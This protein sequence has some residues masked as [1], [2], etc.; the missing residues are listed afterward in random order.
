[1][2]PVSRRALG[3]AI[4]GYDRIVVEWGP[5]TFERVLRVTSA[6][7]G[8][9]GLSVAAELVGAAYTEVES[10]AA[11][12]LHEAR[13]ALAQSQRALEEGSALF[14]TVGS[15]KVQFSNSTVQNGLDQFARSIAFE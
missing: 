6:F 8:E 13:D 2:P 12:V 15:G 5:A 14:R 7:V 9:F 4:S 11:E 3:D 10:V 1:M